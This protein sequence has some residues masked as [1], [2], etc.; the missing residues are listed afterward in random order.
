VPTYYLA[1][2]TRGAVTVALSGDGGD[3]LFAGYDR[4]RAVRLAALLDRAPAARALLGSSFLR[5]LPGGS[6]QKSLVA[7]LK[8]FSQALAAAPARRYAE[9]IAVFG[10]AP[11]ASLYTDDFLAKLPDQDPA[12]F[13]LAGLRRANE[14]D[15][16]T[17]ATLA[18]LVTYLPGDLC[19]KVDIAAMAHGLEC[20]QPMLDHRVV[21]LAVTMPIGLKLGA[22]RGKRIL[23]RAFGDL[24]PAE[25]FRRRKTGFGVPLD[26]WFRGELRELARE[27]L[28]SRQSIDRDFFRREAVE[29]LLDEHQRGARDHSMRLWSLLMLELWHREW[30]P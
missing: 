24:L 26:G 7:R 23:Q 19:H 28:L 3:E 18:D 27:T 6:R 30:L 4:Y 17:A 12:D 1:Q 2:A 5:K 10:E 21:E 14:R 11:R 22:W 9:M 15:P 8:R 16:A 25:V 29:R 20:R 13:V